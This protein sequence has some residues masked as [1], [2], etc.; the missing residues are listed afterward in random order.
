[1]G[2]YARARSV[3]SLILQEPLITDSLTGRPTLGPAFQVS[4]NFPSKE[5]SDEKDSGYYDVDLR[6]VLGTGATGTGSGTGQRLESVSQSLNRP[7]FKRAVFSYGTFHSHR[8]PGD[9]V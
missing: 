4:E 6:D 7:G 8:Q 3:S 1:R 2:I 9:T 5:P